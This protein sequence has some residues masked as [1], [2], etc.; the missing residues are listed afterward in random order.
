M[1]SAV[2]DENK[3]CLMFSFISTLFDTTEVKNW[4]DWITAAN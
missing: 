3:L 2:K 1:E 4:Q